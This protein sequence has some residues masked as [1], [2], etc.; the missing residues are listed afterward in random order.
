MILMGH[1]NITC[2]ERPMLHH[3]NTITSLLEHYNQA[4]AW[5]ITA[6]WYDNRVGTVLLWY[7]HSRTAVLVQHDVFTAVRYNK[8]TAT[9]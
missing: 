2:T 4:A 1:Y 9:L 7:K 3:L 5:V 8:I 6:M